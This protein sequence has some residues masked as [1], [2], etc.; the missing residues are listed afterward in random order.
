MGHKKKSHGPHPIP[1]G[2][3]PKAGPAFD[4]GSED[5]DAADQ[6]D[7]GAGF[8]EQD[9]QRRLGNFETAGEHAYV[10]PGGNNDAQKDG[11]S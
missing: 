6:T 2:N 10:Q 5:P 4:A 8:A 7:G 1:P 3:Q 9:A 11:R